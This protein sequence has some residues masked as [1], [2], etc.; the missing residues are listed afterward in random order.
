MQNIKSLICFFIVAIAEKFQPEIAGWFTY[1]L[2]E[3][4]IKTSLVKL[5]GTIVF[6]DRENKQEFS[7]QCNY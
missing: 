6:L 1:A 7:Q 5:D 4:Q 2:R 3:V